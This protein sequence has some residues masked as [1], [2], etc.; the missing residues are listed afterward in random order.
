ML[1]N[2]FDMKQLIR[3]SLPSALW[4]VLRGARWR[5]ASRTKSSEWEYVPEGWQAA[6]GASKIKGWNVQE[7]L[8]VYKAKWPAFVHSLQGTAPFGLSPEAISA[9]EYDLT[10]HNSIMCY[11]YALTLAS[12]K[13]TTIAMLD[14]GGGIGHYYLIS[15][16]L[17]PDL[18]IDYH[19]KDVPVLTEHGKALFPQ[20]HFYT[21]ETC[22]ARQYDFILAGTSLH[23][24][25]D[26]ESL[27]K[28]LATSTRGY[29][30][31]TGLPVVHQSSSFVF[32]QR[33]YAYGYNT[34]YLGWCLNRQEFLWLAEIAG[35][36]LKR[37]F[38]IGYRP[39]IH[40]AP[41]QCEYHGYLFGR[42]VE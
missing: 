26:W 3:H 29:L 19:C 37:E 32:V 16:A 2:T 14:W 11:A 41:E 25:P 5:F 40:R 28:K 9:A 30:L 6:Q 35:L 21:D 34:E 15:R 13:K 33:P 17:V 24:T 4:R 27:L 22:L 31:V 8:E 20:A 10:F 1:A 36:E 18:E 38:M 7:V 23:Y 42:E 39:F 12:R